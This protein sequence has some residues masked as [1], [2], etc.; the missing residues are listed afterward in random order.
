MCE[1]GRAIKRVD[2]P[3]IAGWGLFGQPSLLGKD[4]VGWEA[5]L[6]DVDDALLRPVVG[7]GHE[8]D[9]LLVFDGETGTCGFSEY[10]SGLAGC[11]RRDRN[12]SV[13]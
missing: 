11:I 3:F 4:G 6:N 9:D 1:V 12:D 5:L 8:V 7:V 2:Y 10:G 13:A